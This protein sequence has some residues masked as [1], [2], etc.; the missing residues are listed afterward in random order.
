LHRTNCIGFW[1]L[2]KCAAST[3][4]NCDTVIFKSNWTYLNQEKNGKTWFGETLLVHLT[5]EIKEFSSTN[6][7]PILYS[8]FLKREVLK[9]GTFPIKKNIV[10]N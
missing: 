2:E 1:H 7:M 6:K 5:V 10:D 8:N 3:E 9:S 4:E